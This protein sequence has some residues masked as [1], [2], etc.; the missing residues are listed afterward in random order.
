MA[1][2]YRVNVPVTP[3]QL[4]D[5]FRSAGL[6]RPVDDLPRLQRMLDGADLT[7]TAWDGDQLVGVARCLT[8]GSW[9]CY[10]SDLA[11]ASTHQK[12]GIGKALV[13]RVRQEIGEEVMLLL[14]SVPDAMEYYP[15]LGFEAQPR[16]WW[17]PRKR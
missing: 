9:C 3:A 15:R 14:L 7:V 13:D 4:S 8:D 11:V 2:D 10:L 12:Q 5:V 16:A 17:I 6:S 1:L